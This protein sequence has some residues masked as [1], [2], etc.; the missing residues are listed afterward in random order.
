MRYRKIYYSSFLPFDFKTMKRI[1]NRI[2]EDHAQL[3]VVHGYDHTWRLNSPR[4]S[5][6]S[7]LNW[8]ILKAAELWKSTRFAGLHI[9]TANGLNGKNHRKKQTAY[10]RCAAICFETGDSLIVPNPQFPT[11]LRPGEH[12][13]FAKPYSNWERPKRTRNSPSQENRNSFKK[14]TDIFLFYWRRQPHGHRFPNK[15]MAM[16]SFVPFNDWNGP[17]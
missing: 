12:H 1:G 15:G 2:D 4:T 6:K 5:V 16:R 17:K 10:P 9:Y 13:R 3:N 7:C 14:K 11:L 8:R